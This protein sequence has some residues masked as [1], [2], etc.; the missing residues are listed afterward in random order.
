M[1][2]FINYVLLLGTIV[3][4][5]VALKFSAL[6]IAPFIPTRWAAF[7]IS[8]AEEQQKYVL[9]YDTAVGFIMSAL[10]YFI[11]DEIPNEVR[12]HRAKRLIA[13]QINQLVRDMEQIIDITIWKYTINQHICQLIILN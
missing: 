3:S 6:P 13:L 8:S 10:F 7:W 5:V 12:L 11:V 4:V 9:L 2:K 1:K